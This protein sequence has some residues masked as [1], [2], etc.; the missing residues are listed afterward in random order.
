MTGVSISSEVCLR[1]HVTL[2][3][4]RMC[5]L[6]YVKKVT[7]NNSINSIIDIK[8]TLQLYYNYIFLL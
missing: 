5:H 4:I 7:F 1:T 6:L 2:L 3:P 8:M